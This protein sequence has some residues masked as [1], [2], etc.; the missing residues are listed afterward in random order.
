[1]LCTCQDRPV[2]SMYRNEIHVPIAT[3]RRSKPSIWAKMSASTTASVST[4]CMI[5]VLFLLGSDRN[6]QSILSSDS[7]SVHSDR[8]SILITSKLTTSLYVIVTLPGSTS[9]I[10]VH[11]A[12]EVM[13]FCCH[14]LA[15]YLVSLQATACDHRYVSLYHSIFFSV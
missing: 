13:L 1:M 14:S 15:R 9:A 11:L 7:S 8:Q 4:V 2:T 3:T 5:I 12:G 10:F 6:M